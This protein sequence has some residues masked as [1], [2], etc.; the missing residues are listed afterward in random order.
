MPRISGKL[1]R[2]AKKTSHLLVPLLRATRNLESARNELRWI[3]SE[4]P[5]NKWN[6]AIARRSR[7]EPLQYILGSQPFGGV[8]IR[9]EPG[10]LIPRWETE[11]WT[12]AL[13]EVV[14]DLQPLD[15]VD[16]CTGTGC[17]PILMKY[18][19][20][21]WNIGSFDIS[22]NA[23]TLAGKNCQ[24]SKCE[25]K[26]HHGNVFDPAI[27]KNWDNIDLITSNPPYI[28]MD[29]YR[30][31]VA[32][33][34]PEE[35]VRLYEPQLALVGNLEFYTALMQNLVLKLECE[36]FVFELGYELQ[37]QETAKLLPEGWDYGRYFDSAGNLRCVV[38]WKKGSELAVLEILVNEN[39]HVECL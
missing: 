11:E 15:V 2:L 29:D 9:C 17:I 34:G 21:N 26:L 5:K 3:K 25:V 30:K 33:D 7:L 28:P 13:V 38:G 31:P 32:L 1:V 16:A 4:L 14:R 6:S 22:P 10:V 36:G 35:S 19:L 23:V 37:V 27:V 20:P 39:R 8:D 24:I 12:L 18:E